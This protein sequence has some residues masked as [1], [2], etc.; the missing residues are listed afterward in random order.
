VGWDPP[1][2]GA[3]DN[4]TAP[5]PD[6]RTEVRT[7]ESDQY[8]TD[9]N[10]VRRSERCHV[11]DARVGVA[12]EPPQVSLAA[13]LATAQQATRESPKLVTSRSARKSI[14][15]SP[16]TRKFLS[17]EAGPSEPP[18]APPTTYSRP[19]I[20]TEGSRDA[21]SEVVYDNA[22]L[23]QGEQ[24]WPVAPLPETVF[25]TIPAYRA[26]AINQEIDVRTTRSDNT[27]LM[28]EETQYVSYAAS[29]GSSSSTRSVGKEE[30]RRRQQRLAALEEID[31]SDV[32]ANIQSAVKGLS[33]P[34]KRKSEGS[35]D[36]HTR[37]AASY[38]MK[39]HDDPNKR[40]RSSSKM[41]DQLTDELKVLQEE[42][43]RQQELYKV[44]EQQRT[45]SARRSA[46][47]D[48]RIKQIKREQVF[49]QAPSKVQ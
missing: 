17:A 19:P 45:E 12:A 18:K 4:P 3:P 14:V 25:R 49:Q 35:D 48:Q 23:R 38:R 6:Q 31:S 41:Q 28:N 13:E 40:G 26:S 22:T 33:S 46:D 34:I 39:D 24:R 21:T 10:T 36:F 27:D 29:H 47:I 11:I 16:P 20:M 37:I 5:T 7:I 32:D 9:R 1:H 8:E 43:N 15:G 42:Q 30:R 44:L 2:L